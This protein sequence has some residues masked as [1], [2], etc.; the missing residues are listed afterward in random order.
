MKRI[1]SAWVVLAIFALSV[2]ANAQNAVNNP[3]VSTPTADEIIARHITAIGGKDNLE[4]IKNVVMEGSLTVN[5]A[6]I[7]VIVTQVNNKL[8][9]QDIT[10]MG[11]TGYDFM[12][13]KEGWTFM[14]FQGMQKPEPKTPDEIRESQS[15]LDI[16]G[17]LYNYAAKGNKV[18][19]LVTEEVEG[20]SCNKIKV[21]L[22]DT[23]VQTYFIDAKSDLIVKTLEK[24]KING[25]ELELSTVFSD[26]REVEGIKMPFSISGM[27][28]TILFSSIKVN[29][30]IDDKLYK[31][32]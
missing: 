32:E 17:A 25:K 6:D 2:N 29:Q 4:K 24:R 22:A 13:D 3:T 9:R 21:I 1:R 18:E 11:M 30:V 20:T 19:L 27:Y 23:R 12:T 15:D 31:H 5:G 28:G 8:M 14:P 26:Y 10:A 16:T 7:T